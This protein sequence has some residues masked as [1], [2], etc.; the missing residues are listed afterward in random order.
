MIGLKE[1]PTRMHDNFRVGGQMN[2]I[3]LYAIGGQ[4]NKIPLYAIP[5]MQ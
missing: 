2:E 4:M 3:P 1:Y 5:N